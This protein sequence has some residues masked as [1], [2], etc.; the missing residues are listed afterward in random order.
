MAAVRNLAAISNLRA[1]AEIRLGNAARGG[2]LYA[3][4]LRLRQD[5][6][7]L[8]AAAGTEK[9]VVEAKQDVATSF[10]LVARTDLL[11]GEPAKAAENWTAADKILDGLPDKVKDG[12]RTIYVRAGLPVRRERAEIRVRLGD[13]QFKQGK[14]DAAD[15]DYKAGLDQREGLLKITK[16]EPHAGFLRSDIAYSR[17]TLGTSSWPGETT[18]RRPRPV[19]DALACSR[20]APGRPGQSEPEAVAGHLH[21]RLGVTTTAGP[22]PLFGPGSPER[23]LPATSRSPWPFGPSWRRRM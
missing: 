2:E 11:L 16:A 5:R 1:D 23:L 13:T 17:L 18:R 21:Y 15:A 7:K 4:G 3:D 19:P 12:E 20:V 22:S 6:V 10:Q 14:R 9:E 8:V